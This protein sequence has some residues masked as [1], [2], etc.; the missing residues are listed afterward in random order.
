M[1]DQTGHLHLRLLGAPEVRRDD[2]VVHFRSRKVLALLIYLA[3]SGGEHSRR[4]LAQLFWP[5]SDAQ[6]GMAALRNT[7]RHLRD[8]LAD[9]A[10]GN[11]VSHLLADDDTLAFDSSAGASFDVHVLD[12][13]YRLAQV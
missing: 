5:E 2:Q 12:A 13:A 8:A 10:G 3:V 7:L 11:T 9:E 6:R 1:R 4:R